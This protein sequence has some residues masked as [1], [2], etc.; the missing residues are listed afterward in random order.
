MKAFEF[1]ESK[2]LGS[3]ASQS[4]Y[5][6]KNEALLSE[7]MEAYAATRMEDFNLVLKRYESWEAKLILNDTCWGGGVPIMTSDLHEEFLEI[8]ELRNLALEKVKS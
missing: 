2:G 8:Q 7:L 5:K 3:C 4:I 1:L 6:G